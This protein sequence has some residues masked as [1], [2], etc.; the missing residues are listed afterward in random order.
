M[1]AATATATGCISIVFILRNTAQN[2]VF[3][4]YST[5][6]NGVAFFMDA[7]CVSN[8]FLGYENESV[9]LSSVAPNNTHILWAQANN[10]SQ[11]QT[12]LIPNVATPN[13]YTNGQGNLIRIV[14]NIS[15]T[16]PSLNGTGTLVAAD[17]A[18]KVFA[19]FNSALYSKAQ[20][21]SVRAKL[22]VSLGTSGG[23]V[24]ESIA[25]VEFWYRVTDNGT[26]AA[27][28]SVISVSKK[29]TTNYIAG[30]KFLTGVAAALGFGLAVV[31][32]NV[33]AALATHLVVDLELLSFTHDTN[34]VAMANYSSVTWGT[35]PATAN[36]VTDAIDLL[37]V[38]D[39]AV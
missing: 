9:A 13:N 28:L 25:E 21:P 37:T 8:I 38:A 10:R 32:G 31:G 34:S 19:R 7:S 2:N 35:V 23:G 20:R 12:M 6:C 22:T 29:P 18:S 1:S 36:D 5:E 26:N 30:L 24:G 17:P 39:T 27:Q 4:G 3:S 16:M 15:G 11:V 33:G 14:Q